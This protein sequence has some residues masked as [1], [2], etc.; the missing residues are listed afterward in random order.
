MLPSLISSNQTAYL[1]ARFISDE[2]RLIPVISEASNLL[3]LERLLL[4]VDIEKL[5]F[6]NCNFLLKVLEN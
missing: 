2:G 3:K 4:A 6:V 1:N 5:D